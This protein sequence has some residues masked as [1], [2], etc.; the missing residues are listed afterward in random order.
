MFGD[1]RRL[2]AVLF[3]DVVGSTALSEGMDPED[4]RILM[5]RYFDHAVAVV[6]ATGGRLEKFIGDA[7]VAVFGLPRA[8]GDEAE[9]ALRASLELRR[10]VREDP[11]LAA[12]L[13]LRIG[14]DL[15]EVVANVAD[16]TDNQFLA[17]GSVMN[18]AAR[19]EQGAEPDEVLVGDRVFSATE[20]AFEFGPARTVRMKGRPGT[21]RVHPVRAPRG[22][23]RSERPPLVGRRQDLLQLR[24]TAERVAE[25]ER[26]RLVTVLG[27]GGIG[28]TRL[29]EE[30]AAG[31]PP[32]LEFAA[33]TID[34]S[35]HTETGS[36]QL[37]SLL[38]GLAGTAVT[39]A[40]VREVLGG[41]ELSGEQADAHAR[42]VLA[43]LGDGGRIGAD[44]SAMLGAL[45]LFADITVQ[46]RP[47]VIVLEE[48]HRASDLM[49][50][51]VE[52]LATPRGAS[53]VLVV[54]VARPEL[55]SRRPDWGGGHENHISLTLQP[56][57]QG[58]TK[59][60]VAHYLPRS[61][62]VADAIS[63][64]AGGNP[65]YALEFVR[66]VASTSREGSPAPAVDG[67][68]PPGETRLPDN[69][70]AAVLA[71]LDLLS[72]AA[73]DVLRVVS[74]G[75]AT[76][77]RRVYASLLPH[78]SGSEIESGI[79]ELLTQNVAHIEGAGRLAIRQSFVREVAYGTLSRAAAVG[80]HC[81]IADALAG[82]ANAGEPAEGAERLPTVI[83][84]HLLTALELNGRAAIPSPLPVPTDLVVERLV[85]AGTVASRAGL[86]LEAQEFVQGAL[87][88]AGPAR[89]VELLE[90]L[91]T[92]AGV[93]E[94]S[95]RA[96]EAALHE[97][98][99]VDRAAGVDDIDEGAGVDDGGP[100]PVRAETA[101]RLRRKLL[102]LWLRCGL[103][104]RL[105]VGRDTI[106][107]H[108][109]AANRA[110]EAL[111]PAGEERMRLKTVDLFL[112]FDRSPMEVVAGVMRPRADPA[113]LVEAGRAIAEHFAAAGETAAASEA[114]DGCQH[115]AFTARMPRLALEICLRRAALD[116]LPPTERT[117]AVAMLARAH[118]ALGDPTA[119]IAAIETEISSR[120]YGG[121]VGYLA[122]A[123]AYGVSIAYS[124][125]EWDTAEAL[126]VHLVN[127]AQELV[128]SPQ[129]KVFCVDGFLSLVRISLAREER[130]AANRFSQLLLDCLHETPTLLP[131]GKTM[132]ALELRDA[133]AGAGAGAGG[134][135]ID[136][137]M[138]GSQS[139]GVVAFNNERGVTSPP[140][141]IAA[142]GTN[143]TALGN[144]VL[145]AGHALRDGDYAALADCIR[146]L[147]DKRHRV[148]AA[149]L[150][151]VLA[152]RTGDPAELPTAQR[153]LEELR[154]R[155]FLRRL[156]TVL[157]EVEGR[158]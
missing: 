124:S 25:E 28:K 123:L 7:V 103:M 17:S 42:G 20:D 31:L 68:G 154:D 8:H 86:A 106:I 59:S 138:F 34:A 71:R 27:V 80:L 150:R 13:R 37:R 131:V 94:T 83:G 38:D 156:E 129:D 54:A 70:H 143:E 141:L 15:G 149:R 118:S 21:Y 62:E 77:P 84:R 33:V 85:D 119:A 87:S 39:L 91:G 1:E 75:G 146:E 4:V 56:L 112:V 46:A 58:Q 135:E 137:D 97:L 100:D 147:D 67:A 142:A 125:G 78:L 19:L 157:T 16:E 115:V 107:E 128:T 109:I 51:L 95:V 29:V 151:I 114:L 43:A 110:A 120:R 89:R 99:G 5:R 98:E 22:R 61:E 93:S 130:A 52:Q 6:E 148:A 26:A 101:V 64:R 90:L 117:D 66:S 40:H 73:R 82:P 153:V 105:R 121:Q 35:R 9:R 10:A 136:V 81:A 49:L 92:V 88:S 24:L 122:Q 145:R 53:R 47:V 36:D 11:V 23:R 63:R 108:Y 18:A 3:A 111:D 133:A 127:A 104:G 132:L 139:L 50:S 32:E 48:A 45:R 14:V 116:D 69:V 126:G 41:W 55:L 96:L 30:F 12:L 44:A 65:F 60:L 140:E 144:G 152:E 158:G 155:R 2:V 79:E 134:Q 72:D 102:I 76:V 57:T 74:V 113:A